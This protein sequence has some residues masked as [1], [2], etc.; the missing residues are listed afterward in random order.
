MRFLLGR[1]WDPDETIRG[2]AAAGI[3]AS[4]AVNRD[5]GRDVVRRLVWALNDESA[6]NGVYGLAAIGEI[7]VRDPELIEPFVGP[8]AC[9]AWDDGLG[10]EIIRA[11]GRI[12]DTA[13]SSSHPS[14]TTS[15]NG[16][17][18]SMRPRSSWWRNSP[19]RLRHEQKREPYRTSGA[20]PESCRR[21]A[22]VGRGPLQISVWPP[23]DGRF[24]VPR[25]PTCG[26]SRS[27]PRLP[28]PG[29]IWVA[30]ACRPGISRAVWTLP[31][32]P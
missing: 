10:P 20:V 3:G 13:R 21:Q 19:R 31:R 2:R 18:A 24:R 26:R 7:G 14:S 27:T 6:T 28:R 16:W 5:L 8:V 23:E 29:S 30:S 25:R 22:A 9:Y 32:R 11:L 12:A 4:A 15:N 17:T 1:L